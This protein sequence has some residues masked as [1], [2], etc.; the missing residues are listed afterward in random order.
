M[1]F[2]W[3]SENKVLLNF[4]G[5]FGEYLGYLDTKLYVVFTP[6]WGLV[7]A[8]FNLLFENKFELGEL[9]SE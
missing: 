9:F 1:I 7:F 8:L 3:K 4:W 2:F 5:G 6:H